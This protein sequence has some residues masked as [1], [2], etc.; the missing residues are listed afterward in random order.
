MIKYYLSDYIA[1][2]G[3]LFVVISC[4]AKGDSKYN[5]EVHCFI[6][7]SQLQSAKKD[8]L[9]RISID[10][11][12]VFEPSTQL[13]MTMKMNLDTIQGHLINFV[14]NQYSSVKKADSIPPN[15]DLREIDKNEVLRNYLFYQGYVDAIKLL[16]NETEHSELKNFIQSLIALDPPTIDRI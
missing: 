8:S 1:K 12:G 14:H 3:H 7:D 10:W 5:S 6:I 16:N 13:D 11:K 9:Q 15:I 2:I 4:E